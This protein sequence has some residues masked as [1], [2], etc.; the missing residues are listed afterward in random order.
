[1]ILQCKNARAQETAICMSSN[2]TRV[3]HETLSSLFYSTHILFQ[4]PGYLMSCH[5]ISKLR[6]ALK[7]A[8]IRIRC[9]SECVV[10]CKC[11]ALA[12]T[13]NLKASCY[14]KTTWVKAKAYVMRP[15]TINLDLDFTTNSS[16]S[17]FVNS[18]TKSQFARKLS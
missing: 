15:K 18:K 2:E 9:C 5:H 1:M 3:V 4:L 16:S 7:C 13:L 14:G 10:L 17:T 6:R 11:Q 8:N 12:F